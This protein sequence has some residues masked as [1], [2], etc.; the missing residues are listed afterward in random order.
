MVSRVRSCWNLDVFWRKNQE[1]F[2]R[3]DVGYRRKEVVRKDR[4]LT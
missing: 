2:L 1:D 3:L 4:F